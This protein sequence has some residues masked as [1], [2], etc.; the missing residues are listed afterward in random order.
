MLILYT[1]NERKKF[2]NK[3]LNNI[4]LTMYLKKLISVSNVNYFKTNKISEFISYIDKKIKIKTKSLSKIKE[5]LIL[6]LIIE[7][8]MNNSKL[9]AFLKI[10][11]TIIHF[12]FTRYPSI[13]PH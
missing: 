6:I 3:I 4:K 13:I 2:F 7:I 9:K 11:E 12:G 10:F 8:K 1:E 5:K